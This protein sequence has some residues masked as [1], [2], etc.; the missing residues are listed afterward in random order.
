[1]R[2][3][4]QFFSFNPQPLYVKHNILKL[5]IRKFFHKI[6]VYLTQICDLFPVPFC[7]HTFRYLSHGFMH[8]W[9]PAFILYLSLS[10]SPSSFDLTHSLFSSSHMIPWA[11]LCIFQACFHFRGFTHA[12]PSFWNS[13]FPDIC[14]AHA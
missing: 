2:Q 3:F 11:Y 7:S 12:P 6:Y 5:Q 8:S 10:A 9:I 14:T 4:A 1:M 13:L